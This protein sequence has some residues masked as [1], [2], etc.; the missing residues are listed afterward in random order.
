MTPI[1]RLDG[2]VEVALYV[3][4]IER[5]VRFY[6][7][8]FGFDVIATD[9]R[10]HALGVAGRQVLLVCQKTASAKL[11]AGSHYADGEQHV[12]FAVPAAD[13]DAWRARLD[14]QGVSIEETR[15]WER[16]GRSVYFRDPDRHLIELVTPGVWSIY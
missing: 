10:L 6:R 16:G 3:D 1:P 9:E 11:A 14:A 4:Q 2:V 15:A 12:A 8:V 7:N 13:F 5:S